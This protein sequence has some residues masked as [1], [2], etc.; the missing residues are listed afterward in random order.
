MTTKEKEHMTTRNI[1]LLVIGFVLL[2][3]GTVYGLT[4]EVIFESW[5][6]ST[7][8]QI[9][10]TIGGITAP[11]INIVGSIL[12]FISFL[13]QNKANKIQAEH[14]SFALLHELYKDLKDDFNNLSFYSKSIGN[15][16]IYQGKRALSVFSEVLESRKD[17]EDFKKNSYF[18]ELLFL[19]GSFSILL[20]IVKTSNV[21]ETEK[22]YIFRLI[23]FLYTTR[24]KE[25]VT[26]IINTTSGI[27]QHNDFH[28]T[29]YSFDSKIEESFQETF[30]QDEIK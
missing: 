18:N 9:G 4:R 15:G 10:D 13:S 5:G 1:V 30:G 27:P 29:L 8:G 21:N 3:F 11:I 28:S 23:H 7:T 2:L 16:N 24:I 12:I 25:H 22:K 26:K 17:N 6:L 14:N 20:N 19:I